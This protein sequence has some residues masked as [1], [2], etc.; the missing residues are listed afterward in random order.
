MSDLIESLFQEFKNMG[1]S[2]E[3]AEKL[4]Q[5]TREIMEICNVSKNQ[6]INGILAM[7]N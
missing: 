4:A 2:K 7:L 1:F 3:E 6:A 5:H